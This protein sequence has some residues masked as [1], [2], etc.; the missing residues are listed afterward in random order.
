M[1]AEFYCRLTGHGASID[2][3]S[4]LYNLPA[5][6]I[7]SFLRMSF[8]YHLAAS[9]DLP[10]D[11]KERVL[12]PQNFPISVLERLYDSTEM[13]KQLTLSD[14]L[15]NIYCEPDQFKKAYSKIVSDIAT[16]AQD[17]R[18]LNTSDDI[19][20]YAQRIR[21]FAGIENTGKSTTVESLSLH[22]HEQARTAKHLRKGAGKKQR[23]TR[24]T[25][26]LFNAGAIPFRL[27][28]AA[29]LKRFYDELRSLPV[30]T[31]PNTSAILLRVFT[32]K[33]CRHFLKRKGVKSIQVGSQSTKLSDVSFGEIL[34]YLTQR[35]NRLIDDDNTKKAIRTFKAGSS[36]KSL[37]SL[38]TIIHNEEVS[39]A[40]QQV[41]DLLPNL[42]GLMK[43]I[44]TE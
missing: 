12:D 19:R 9:M 36:F 23:S 25:K 29:S 42:E 18:S 40:E 10:Q 7:Q 11:V 41:R 4:R 31:Y 22:P 39:F 16:G 37:S 1:Q 20:E 26:G 2:E 32:D 8:M 38:N 44:L 33:A 13:R 14:D 6:N 35:S 24:Q 34:D 28:G 15:S 30:A 5:G 43:I 3:I 17:T 27:K 21:N